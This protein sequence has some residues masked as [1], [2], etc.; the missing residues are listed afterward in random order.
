MRR[1]IPAALIAMALA[2]GSL[3]AQLTFPELQ[4]DAVDPLKFPANIHLGE[5]AGVA[6]N[7]NGDIFVYTRT[8]TPMITTAGSRNV[9]HYGSRLFM[10][11]KTGKF[12]REM[13]QGVYGFLQAQQARVDPQGNIWVVDQLANQV[14]KFDP[15]GR[16]VMV[17]GRKPEAMRVP[18]NPLSVPADTYALVLRTPEPPAT[19]GAGG[20]PGGGGGGGGQGGGGQAAPGGQGGGGGGQ[21]GA[22]ARPPGS[23]AEGESFNRPTD[24]AWDS[25]GNIYVADGYGNSRVAKYDKNGKWVKNWGHTGT[26]PGQF[27]VV[28]G[29]AID[30][31]NNVYVADRDNRRIQVFDTEG[32]FKTQYRNVGSPWAICITPG[33]KQFMYVSNSNPPNNLDY[34]GEILK[35]SLDGKIVGKFGRAGKLPKEFG[36]VNAIDCRVENELLV[37][38]LG[39]WRVQKVTLRNN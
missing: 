5:A 38:E 19:P 14:I 34:D 32:T 11:D 33:A 1:L 37:G 2:T 13:G 29:I 35:M 18:A 15:D 39:N 10:F 20:G 16:V 7:A 21:G 24:V 23:G 9:S 22:A 26:E 27:R 3:S 17:L 36:T 31:A 6:T 28:H 12:V 4:Y 30:S 25:T 8:G